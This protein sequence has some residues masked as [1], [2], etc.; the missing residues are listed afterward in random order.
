[1]NLDLG[2]L[3]ID[4][5]NILA[6]FLQPVPV[7]VIE[8]FYIFGWAFLAYVCIY[9]MVF[10][11]A[12][13]KENQYKKDWKWVVYA[14]DIPQ[15]NVQT[16]LAVEQMFSH[17]AGAFD[18]PN[19]AGKFRQGYKQRWFSFEIISIEGYIQFLIR[20]EESL[21]DLVEAAMYAQYPEV[22]I[23]E[24]ED[25]VDFVP[26]QYPNDTHDMWGA[27]FG[28]A[29]DDAYPIRTYRDFEHSIAKD[30]VLKDPMGTFLESFTRIGPGEQMWFQILVQPVS[31]SWKEGAIRAIKKLIG[32]KGAGPKSNPVVDGASQ[33]IKGLWDDINWQFTG[34]EYEPG[35]GASGG[36]D[37]PKNNLSFLTPGQ[38]KILEAMED[39][40]SKIGFKTKLRGIYVARKE[41]F[42]PGRGVHALIGAI[43]QFNV[44]SANS[45]VPKSGV[46]ASYFF[47][48]SREEQK[49]TQMMKAYKK[50]KLATGA[51]PFVLNIEELATIWHFPMSHVK[52]PLVQKAADKAVE[53]PSSLP[54]ESLGSSVMLPGMESEIPGSSN[55]TPAHDAPRAFETDAGSDYEAGQEFG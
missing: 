53:P 23:T 15:L 28:L 55:K 20:T 4:T 9:L 10:Y 19:I 52:T 47:A 22:D 38:K 13:Y 26:S 45:I 1:M 2:I 30:T 25:Y 11:L 42:Q 8:L 48:K 37:G 29:E 12:E 34:T 16:P 33:L 40:I 41:V 39:K 24:V 21:R 18:S 17:L 32:E 3:V 5:D 51:N 14:I 36:D 44:P 43:N 49:K 54:V 27:D 6:F 31:N 46:S 7:V 35:G 50:R